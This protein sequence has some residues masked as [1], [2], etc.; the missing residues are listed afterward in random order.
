[1]EQLPGLKRTECTDWMIL[2]HMVQ[3]RKNAELDHGEATL[4][5]PPWVCV[6]HHRAESWPETCARGK[7][8]QTAKF[9]IGKV[10][11]PQRHWEASLRTCGVRLQNT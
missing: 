4:K 9:R 11:L 2:D 1:M 7:P 10:T 8:T 5:C 6:T 3:Q